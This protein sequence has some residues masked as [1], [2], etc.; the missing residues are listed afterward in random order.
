MDPDHWPV[1]VVGPKSQTFDGLKALR[2]GE[3]REITP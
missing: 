2:I 3:I 1:V